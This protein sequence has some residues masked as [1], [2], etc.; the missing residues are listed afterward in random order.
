MVSSSLND[1]TTDHI[2]PGGLPI[3]GEVLWMSAALA[4][5]AIGLVASRAIKD[6]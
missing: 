1:L 4:V 2:L 5:L 6:I 3:N